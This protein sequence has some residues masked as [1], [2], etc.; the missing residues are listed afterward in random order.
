MER[1]ASDPDPLLSK[2]D[3][4]VNRFDLGHD[5][6]IPL[7]PSLTLRIV[8]IDKR[9]G[10]LYHFRSDPALA[11]ESLLPPATPGMVNINLRR[12]SGWGEVGCGRTERL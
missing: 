2:R 7:V 6:L 10:A 8:C 4:A 1:E 3:D 11:Q 9:E 12:S 5:R